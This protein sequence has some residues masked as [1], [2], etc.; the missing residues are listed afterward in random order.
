[1]QRRDTV[2]RIMESLFAELELPNLRGSD[3]LGTWHI[4]QTTFPMWRNGKNTH[5]TLNYR[6]IPGADDSQLEDLVIYRKRGAFFHARGAGLKSK[7][8]RGVDIQD[9]SLSCHFT[10]RGRG[11]LALL[12]SEWYVVDFMRDSAGEGVMAIYFSKTLFT[13]AGMD[14]AATSAKPR[15][16]AI[17]ACIDRVRASATLRPHVEAL[18]L[19]SHD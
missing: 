14:I 6:P 18:V 5:P 2:A 1:V 3:L 10:W 11:L 12:T 9:P 4:M 17:A 15:A 7:Q 8:I 19:I 13:P 16:E